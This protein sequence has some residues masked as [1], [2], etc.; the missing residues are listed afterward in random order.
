MAQLAAAGSE[1]ERQLPR[2]VRDGVGKVELAEAD[3]L[4]RLRLKS[5][6]ERGHEASARGRA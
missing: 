2:L 4:R 1:V 6:R 3:Q 5:V